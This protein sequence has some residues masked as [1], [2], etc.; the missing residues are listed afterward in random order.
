MLDEFRVIKLLGQ[1]GASKVYLAKDKVSGIEVA[2]KA[3]QKHLM[4]EKQHH[5]VSKRCC[6]GW[7]L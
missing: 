1:G 3:Y 7:K 5:A 2:L 6:W 4:R